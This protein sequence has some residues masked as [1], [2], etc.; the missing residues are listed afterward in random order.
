[1]K[2]TVLESQ[3]NILSSRAT[4]EIASQ[5]KRFSSKTA[6]VPFKWAWN[7]LSL[8]LQKELKNEPKAFFFLSFIQEVRVLSKTRPIT[9]FFVQCRWTNVQKSVMHLRSCCF[10]LI[11][12]TAFF[13]WRFYCCGFCGCINSVILTNHVRNNPWFYIPWT[14]CDLFNINAF[15][16]ANPLVE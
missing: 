16:P 8:K 14:E 7:G 15:S 12:T 13:I 6:T 4:L 3:F 1:M 2:M 9:S 10:A 5:E 11:N